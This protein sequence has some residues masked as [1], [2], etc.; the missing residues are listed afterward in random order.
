MTRC[1]VQFFHG[2]FL[3]ALKWNPLVFTALCGLTAFLSP[4]ALAQFL[5]LG[6][7]ALDYW[8]VGVGKLTTT[9][10]RHSNTPLQ[11][12]SALLVLRG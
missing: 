6:D 11:I 2:H 8:S 3:T 12:F 9:L 4:D 1:G 7:R 10:L 5:T